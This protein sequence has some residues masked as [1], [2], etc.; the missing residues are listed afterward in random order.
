MKEKPKI[1]KEIKFQ[2]NDIYKF[3]DVG[4]HGR[5]FFS[6]E[7]TNERFFDLWKISHILLDNNEDDPI[8][9]IFDTDRGRA[10][11]KS[12]TE[13]SDLNIIPFV[14]PETNKKLYNVNFVVS[15]KYKKKT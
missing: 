2:T 10:L 4:A 3:T 6:D 15:D 14:D 7:N 5:T 1:L 13:G 9:R 12:I 11:Y 8:L